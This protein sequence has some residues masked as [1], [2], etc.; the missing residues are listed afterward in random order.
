MTRQLY[1]FPIIHTPED[2][3]SVREAVRRIHI[4]KGGENQWDDHRRKVEDLWQSIG[5]FIDSLRLD[6]QK[7]ALYQDGLPVCGHE[8]KIVRDLA[9]AGS[10]NHRLLLDLIDKGARLVGAESPEML[11]REYRLMREILESADTSI[12]A[13]VAERLR[14]QSREILH[15]RDR[16]VAE[17]IG[18]TLDPGETGLLFLGML[19]S[20][21]GLLPADIAL[22]EVDALA[23]H[24]S[25]DR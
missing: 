22:T 9:A 10:L 25:A 3:G 11:V 14:A 23:D 17:R 21:A 20:L 8:E 15:Q 4:R 18:Q 13:A 1:W 7:V 12:P 2:L 16:F 19:H 24:D 6:Y 5:S